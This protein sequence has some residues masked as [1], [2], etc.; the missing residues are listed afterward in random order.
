MILRFVSGIGDAGELRDEALLRL[1]VHERH[2]EE[3][4]ERL[5][6]LLGLALAQQA[7]VDEH[8][9]ELVADR[10][11]H[12]Q[13]RDGRVDAAGERAE[14]AL[15]AD[16]G[17]DALDLLLDHRGGR[18]GRR[19]AGDARRGSSSSTSWPCGVCTTSGWNCTP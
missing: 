17:A 18:P 2:V 12:E 11:V 9:G 5:D 16:L 8:A 1:H 19:G 6:H 7:V 10:L 3:A 15:A 4:V 14:H 13:R